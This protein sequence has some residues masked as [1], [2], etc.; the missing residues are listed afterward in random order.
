MSK[1]S[2]LGPSLVEFKL[3]SDSLLLMPVSF[4]A[5][6][7]DLTRAKLLSSSFRF[8]KRQ[9]KAVI[10]CNNINFKELALV[11]YEGAKLKY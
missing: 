11:T 7:S 6:E 8:L 9:H 10:T 4:G 2:L 5:S 1:F 3:L